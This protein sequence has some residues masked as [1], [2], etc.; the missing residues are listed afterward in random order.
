MMNDEDAATEIELKQVMSP[1]NCRQLDQTI[2]VTS[3]SSLPGYGYQG[4]CDLS[5]GYT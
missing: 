5:M 4:R 2:L 1:S 3:L